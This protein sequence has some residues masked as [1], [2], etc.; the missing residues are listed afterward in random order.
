MDIKLLNEIFNQL[1]DSVYLLDPAT[2][3]DVYCNRRGYESLLMQA[4]EVLD[5]SVLTLQKDVSGLPAWD[6]GAA[7]C[8][9]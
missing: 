5:H 8:R 9:D 6:A 7:S 1:P 2:S 3:K 4:E